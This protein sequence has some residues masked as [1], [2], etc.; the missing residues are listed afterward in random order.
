MNS[1]EEINVNQ[2]LDE[3]FDSY[4]SNIS[5]IDDSDAD[6]NFY[7]LGVAENGSIS[8]SPDVSMDNLPNSNVLVHQIQNLSDDE[9]STEVSTSSDESEKDDDDSEWVDNCKT[10]SDFEFNSNSSGIKINI[11]ESAKDSP[12]E[13][14]NQI[15]TEDILDIIISSTNNYGQKLASKDRSHSKYS[16]SS[17]FKNTDKEE[18]NKFLGLC[19]LFGSSRFSVL[20]DAFS[21]NPLYC[22]PIAKKNCREDGLSNSLI[23]SVL[24]IQ[25]K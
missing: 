15:W 21:N 12:I 2:L 23:V 20:R 16:R 5:I 22:Y 4:D 9:Y 8:S 1:R 24:N 3:D 17:T 13:V 14:F 19:L 11:L 25:K 10:I 7:P 18:I 6:P